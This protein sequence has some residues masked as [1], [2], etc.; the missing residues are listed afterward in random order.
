MANYDA[1]VAR[2]PN[3]TL[4]LEHEVYGESS[5]FLP[6]IH[7]SYLSSRNVCVSFPAK[8]IPIIRRDLF[9]KSRSYPIRYSEAQ[10]RRL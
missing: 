8:V 7:F 1:L 5:I 4:S 9:Y 3:T 6:F 2:R 10:R